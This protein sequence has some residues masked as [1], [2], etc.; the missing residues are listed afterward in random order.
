[1]IFCAKCGTQMEDEAKFCPVCG[2]AADENASEQKEAT[3]NGDGT[4]SQQRGG[5]SELIEK[6]KN[7]KI[8]AVI[9]AVVV[10]FVALIGGIIN[11]KKTI[12]L[13]ECVKIECTGADGYGTARAYIDPDRYDAALLK[14]MGK[15]SKDLDNADSWEDLSSSFSQAM[16]TDN[17]YES[18]EIKLNK[19]EKI[20]NGDKLVA[21]ITYDKKLA[22]QAGIKYKGKKVTLKVKDLGK[23]KAYDPFKDLK[24][25]FNGTAEDATVELE[26]TGKLGLGSYDFEVDK[27]Y[28]I[29]EGDTIT[30]TLAVDENVFIEQGIKFKKLTKEY[31]VEGLPKLL[32]DASQ[33]N[34]DNMSKILEDVENEISEAY[35]GLDDHAVYTDLKYEGAY[36]LSAKEGSSA[37]GNRVYVIMSAT[38]SSVEGE[39]DTQKLY[40]P[41]EVV[42]V[43]INGKGEISN[44]FYV[45]YIQGESGIEYN[46]GW[47]ELAGYTDLSVAHDELLGK[48]G[49][50][51]NTSAIDEVQ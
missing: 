10:I 1:M 30:I 47:S 35:Q 26:Y 8:L 19:T 5:A 36:V 50:V 29:K 43:Y 40:L 4:M 37:S 28:D 12:N 33:L 34:Q 46:D 2:A 25:T 20:K 16:I 9:L 27:S 3:S 41:V 11:S 6:I 22:K 42:N 31:K 23:V 48:N 45:T 32:T 39:F 13:E 49:E 14:A 7:P 24:V 38:V 44:D 18:I 15:K 21:T 17:A 51:Y